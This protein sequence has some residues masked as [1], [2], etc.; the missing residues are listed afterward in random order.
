MTC[1]PATFI[2]KYIL[3]CI[4]GTSL[5]NLFFGSAFLPGFPAHVH[6]SLWVPHPLAVPK[7][8]FRP[9]P[10]LL[11]ASAQHW[12]FV[13]ADC[14]PSPGGVARVPWILACF[15]YF[16]FTVMS[17]LLYIPYVVTPEFTLLSLFSLP[18][19]LPGC[20]VGLVYFF[21]TLHRVN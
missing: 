18:G 21:K 8:R 15:P 9:Q 17:L 13:E 3:M 7:G 16:E 6:R 19:S 10:R 4:A 14:S 20:L 1:I 2:F 11:S 5:W 12:T